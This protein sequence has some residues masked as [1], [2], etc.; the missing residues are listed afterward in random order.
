MQVCQSINFIKNDEFISED[1]AIAEVVN[2]YFTNLTKELEI[3][4]S[5]THLSTTHGIDDPIDIAIIKCGK[6]PSIKK[7]KEVLTLSK[8]FSFR[9]IATLEALQQIEK[10]S[11]REASPIYSIP[12]RVLKKT[13]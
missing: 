3:S 8:T 7:I 13:L 2:H 5:K 9:N 6:H 11:N 12:A 4:V 10:L 1:L